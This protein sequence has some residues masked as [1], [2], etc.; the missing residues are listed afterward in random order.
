MLLLKICTTRA[1]RAPPPL[2]TRECCAQGSKAAP[3]TGARL[4]G[5]GRRCHVTGARG[6]VTTR[7]ECEGPIELL[8]RKGRTRTGPI[9]LAAPWSKPMAPQ[10][11]PAEAR[12]AS[13]LAKDWPT[14]NEIA[15]RLGISSSDGSQRAKEKRDE[16]KLLGVWCEQERTFRYPDFQF[17][18]VG[19]LRPEVG[20]LLTTM[21]K[22]PGC[23]ITEDPS[24]WQRT[25][26]LYPPLRSLSRRVIAFR[27]GKLRPIPS[28]PEAAANFFAHTRH[29]VLLT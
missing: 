23:P 26:W 10:L 22:K 15:A 27:T 21:A 5:Q 4:P 17:D 28:D 11:N 12:R 19:Q 24:G 16:G 18:Q 6:A 13:S 7:T 20:Q 25:F 2:A 8:V 1:S 3:R 29:P 14:A 9:L